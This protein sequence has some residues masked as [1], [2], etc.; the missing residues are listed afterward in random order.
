MIQLYRI[1]TFLLVISLSACVS[2]QQNKLASSDE[3]QDIGLGGTGMLANSG[4]G[5][6]GTGIVGVITGFGSIFVNGVEIEYNE[7]TPF[8]INGK[9]GTYQQLAIGDVVEVLTTDAQ[10]H[11]HAQ[12]I[13]LRHEIIG[14]VESVN[15]V[16]L[17]FTIQG[18]TI[19]HP[20]NN[21]TLPTVGD[22]VAVSGFRINNQLIKATRVSTANNTQNYLRTSMEL[23][24]SKLTQNWLIQTYVRKGKT[25]VIHNGKEHHLN[26]NAE[27]GVQVIKLQES[28]A[29]K[30]LLEQVINPAVLPRGR[31]I[32]K[33]HQKSDSIRMQRPGSMQN[34]SFQGNHQRMG[35]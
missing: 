5:L 27:S 4:S 13:N 10:Q 28:A 1:F 22:N 30:I 16:A 15:Q 3:D 34:K 6:G 26:T 31:L 19:T 11:T 8:S 2:T 7:K 35:R 14:T 18:H 21:G 29:D 33:Y 17:S 25:S 23:P 12:I 32:E 24:F 20:L 9:P